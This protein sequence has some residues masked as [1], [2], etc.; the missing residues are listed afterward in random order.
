MQRQ[1]DDVIN[2]DPNA[3]TVAVPPPP[4][5]GVKWSA[6]HQDAW[7]ATWSATN[8]RAGLLCLPVIAAWVF[9]GVLSGRHESAV[10]AVAGAVAVGFV[11]F[12]NLGHRRTRSMIIT[13]VGIC[14]ATFAGCVTGYA[15]RV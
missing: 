13:L 5:L 15:G 14:L 8:A 10:L 3:A 12:Q 2:P 9:I 11:A 4:R 1:Q 7:T 6:I